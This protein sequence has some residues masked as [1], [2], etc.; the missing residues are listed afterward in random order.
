MKKRP[1]IIPSGAALRF[2]CK[3]VGL[4]LDEAERLV[5]SNPKKGT[6]D[7]TILYILTSVSLAYAY[8]ERQGR[9]RLWRELKKDNQ[10]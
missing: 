3:H 5:E 4:T 7:D 10:I 8:G 1:H 6:H 9:R 2:G